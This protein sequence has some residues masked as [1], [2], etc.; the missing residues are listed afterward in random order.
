LLWWL[1]WFCAAAGP[2]DA[3]GAVSAVRARQG[4]AVLGE[5]HVAALAGMAA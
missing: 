4:L 2:R 5:R 1:G 3:E